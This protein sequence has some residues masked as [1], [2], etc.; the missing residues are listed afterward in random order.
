M[1]PKFNTSFIPK[2]SLQASAPGPAVHEYVAR[3]TTRG[4]GFYGTFLLFFIACLVSAGLFMY[5]R[6]L[7]SAIS[8]KI[9]QLTRARDAFQPALMQ[10]LSR[11]DD[12]MEATKLLLEGHTAPSEV[13]R[14]LEQQTIR[15]VRFTTMRY[16]DTTQAEAAR[17]V[18]LTLQGTAPNF[19][20]VAQQS[21]IFAKHELVRNPLFSNLNINETDQA[22]FSASMDLDP[23]VVRF[24]RTLGAAARPRTVAP[25]TPTP[26]AAATATPAT[27]TATT[28]PKRP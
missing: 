8:D 11:L 16:A 14:F 23:R 10:E 22:V 6:Y 20:N 15:T 26:V 12:R 3:R 13:L 28:T 18:S 9:D 5:T 4:P 1:E 25:P 27:S 7:N 17:E 24:D 21:D 19:T 2:Q